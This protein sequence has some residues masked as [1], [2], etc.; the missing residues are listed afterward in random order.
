MP[1]NPTWSHALVHLLATDAWIPVDDARSIAEF[2]ADAAYEVHPI[3]APDALTALLRHPHDG[4]VRAAREL[5]G[6]LPLPLF[7]AYFAALT[8]TSIPASETPP[9]RQPDA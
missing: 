3:E 2:R 4:V 1:S 5:L 8:D 7:R 6:L 9:R